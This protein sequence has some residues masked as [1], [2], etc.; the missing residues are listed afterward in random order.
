M[1]VHTL[2]RC[3]TRPRHARIE[4]HGNFL[5]VSGAGHGGK[6][7]RHA[8]SAH[9]RGRSLPGRGRC[10]GRV[11]RDR[12]GRLPARMRPQGT[13]RF[14][15]EGARVGTENLLGD[16]WPGTRALYFAEVE[17][18]TPLT[19]G[20]YKWQVKTTGSGLGVPHAAGLFTFAVKVVSPPDHEVTVEAFD[21][22]TQAPIKGAHVLLH[23]Y[24]AF[25]NESGLAKVNVARG[26]Y[27]LFD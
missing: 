17:A 8:W 24:R 13:N 15:H 12:P 10:R 25:T 18:Q 1:D 23:P 21:S 27:K 3:F 11:D 2:F 19:P 22:Q 26:T 6:G 4:E 20:D 9:V 14:D 7:S 5:P 16:V